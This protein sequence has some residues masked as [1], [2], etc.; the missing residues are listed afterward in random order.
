M[1]ATTIAVLAAALLLGLDK[2]G[3]LERFGLIVKPKSVGDFE[4]EL[5]LADRKIIRLEA[6]KQAAELKA[7]TLE[8]ERSLEPV[9]QVVER[10][11]THVE[12]MVDSQ[13]QVLDK[14][15]SFNGTLAHLEDGLRDATDAQRSSTEAMKL[16]TGLIVGAAD[17][18][19]AE[20]PAAS[21]P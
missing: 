3:L 1:D 5:K 8:K 11:M 12:V 4:G 6:E 19:L 18:P 17:P 16:I 13:G 15:R 9:M 10:V 14:L 20:R 7:Q 2:F 21:K